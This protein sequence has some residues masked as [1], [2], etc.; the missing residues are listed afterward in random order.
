MVKISV[1]MPVYNASE[2]LEFSCES[3]F[4]QTLKD[5]ELICV[6]DG[7]TDDSLEKLNDLKEKYNF[8][9]IFSQK[10][11]GSG[12]ARNY[13]ISKAIGEYIA[14]LDADDK[15]I[16]INAL[17]KMYFYGFKNNAD[18]VCGNLKRIKPNGE[19]V[20]TYNF[21]KTKFSYFEKKDVLLPIEYGIPFAFYKN[22]FKRSFIL[23]HSIEFPDLIRGQDPIF[24][25]KALVNV[26]EIYVLNTDLYGY[27]HTIGGG[28]NM[29]VN[30]FDKKHDYIQHFK[31]TFDILRTNLFE[32]AYLNYKREFID[33]LIN[34]DNLFNDEIIRL[35]K[36]IFPDF[37]EYF[38]ETDYGFAY[39]DMIVNS[40]DDNVLNKYQEFRDTKRY[41]VEE[42]MINDNFINVDYLRKYVKICEQEEGFILDQVSMTAVKDVERD[43]NNDQKLLLA[44]LELINKEI[45]NIERANA[46]ILSSNS[47]KL[48]ESL[49]HIGRYFKK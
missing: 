25:A 11:Q 46:E 38:D 8:I 48:T 26:D 10:N 43:V 42:T 14:F 3:V 21:R 45:N 24:L 40:G 9:K 34:Q 15:F 35:V 6:D 4:N 32:S 2:F 31:D 28:V 20:E 39:I 1:I 22:I 36:D 13:G 30:T 12:K 19:L 44:E 5:I 7:S 18:I 23:E 16:D 49:R 29:K 47:W 37:K 33:Y 27:N 41:L 17:E